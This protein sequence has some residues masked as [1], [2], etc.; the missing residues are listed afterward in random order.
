[1][2]N[3]FWGRFWLL[4]TLAVICALTAL[5]GFFTYFSAR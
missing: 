2:M 4:L 5:Y 1:M 3:G